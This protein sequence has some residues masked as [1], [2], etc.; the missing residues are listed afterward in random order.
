MDWPPEQTQHKKLE[1]ELQESQQLITTLLRNFPNGSVNVFDRDLCYLLAEGR[2]LQERGLSSEALRGKRLSDLFPPESV[3]VVLPHYER[4]FAGETVE[5]ELILD[6]LCYSINAAPLLVR[7]GEVLTIIAVAQNITARKQAEEL[8]SQHGQRITSVLESITDAFFT[9]DKEWRFTY[10][11][12]QAER[13]L[14]RSRH[15]LLGRNIWKE[16][17]EAVDSTFGVQYRR[18]MSTGETVTFDEYFPPL[19]AWFHVRAY[20][21]ADALSVYFQDVTGSKAAEAAIRESETRFRF[22]ADTVPQQVWTAQP[23]GALD[24]VNQR[25]IKYFGQG[26]Q[27][28]IGRGWQAVLHPDDLAPCLQ[29]WG[30]SLTTGE[31]YNVQF[32]LRRSDGA[33]RWHLGLALPLRDENGTIVQWFGTNTDIEEA[34]Q[35]RR[36]SEEANRLKDEFL[37]TLSHELRTPLNSILGWANLLRSGSPDEATSKQGLEAIERNARVQSQLIEDI[38]DVSR[39]MSGKINLKLLHVDLAT[40]IEGSIESV[41]LSAQAKNIEL[42]THLSSDV[43]PVQGDPIRLQ[44]VIWN[45]LTN[46]IKFTP[47]SGRVEVSLARDAD[48][49]CVTVQDSGQ[50]IAPEF[51]A[52]VF[53]RFRQADSSSTRRHGGLGLGLA[54]VRHL[55]ELHGGTVEVASGGIGQGATFTVKIPLMAAPSM[56]DAAMVSP[57]TSDGTTN[58][59]DLESLPSL[60]GVQVLAVDDEVD[61]LTFL[62]TLLGQRGALVTTATSVEEALACIQRQRPH[63]LISDIGMPQQDGYS[64]IEQ[65]RAQEAEQRIAFLPAVALTAFARAEDRARA[66]E[67][68][69]QMH[70]AKPVDAAQL[71]TAIATLTAQTP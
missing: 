68:G 55:V 52:H 11:N 64:L 54:I 33:Y 25:A 36:A 22:L 35:A 26:A 50:G 16:F 39:I 37:T 45:L 58:F 44:Q 5:F 43:G 3:A 23:D 65:V 19:E 51:L 61:A 15:E 32:R 30:H 27:Q 7:D 38:L 49:A 21:S 31:A 24:Y 8:L 56:A 70:L 1:A 34:W 53:D 66:I 14:R 28:I 46:A 69:F 42:L 57:L 62:S 67:A 9:L 48:M 29:R 2:G 18:A 20:P 41:R 47:P 17:P 10:L 40:A 63:I 60:D 6:D 12:N 13:V 71:I 4:A 59:Q